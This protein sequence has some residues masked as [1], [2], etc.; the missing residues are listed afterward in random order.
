[1]FCHCR[2][3]R[4]DWVTRAAQLHRVVKER[5]AGEE[6][7][8]EQDHDDDDSNSDRSERRPSLREVLNRQP[9]SGASDLA[10]RAPQQQP[11]RT[12]RL[13]V[14]YARVTLRRPTRRTNYQ[15]QINFVELT[16]WVVEARKVNSPSGVEPLH[17]V[18]LSVESGT[19][20]VLILRSSTG[21]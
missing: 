18:F 1:M 2:A 11:A 12:A 15:P 14:R 10:V 19:G 21:G 13:E 9:L 16:Q 17:W 5:V 8:H 7:R 20:E 6:D 3:Q 4:T